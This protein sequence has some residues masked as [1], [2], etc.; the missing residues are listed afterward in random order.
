M[1]MAA[2]K[3]NKKQLD[4]LNSVIVHYNSVAPGSSELIGASE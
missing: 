3:K 1:R 4:M 2:G